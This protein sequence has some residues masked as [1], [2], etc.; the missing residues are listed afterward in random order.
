VKSLSTLR[1]NRGLSILEVLTAMFI[2]GMV[3]SIAY[4]MLF[5]ALSV[6]K[7]VLIEGEMRSRGEAVFSG[8][9][10]ELKDAVY[11]ENTV[12]GN[13][14]SILYIKRSE[15][16]ARYLEQY[17]MTVML[18]PPAGTGDIQVVHA[19]SGALVKSFDLGERFRIRE[20]RL[21]AEGDHNAVHLFLLYGHRNALQKEEQKEVKIDSRIPL[22]RVD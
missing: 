10:S 12:D 14:L 21:T 8:M 22:L 19:Q 7:S 6:Y 2:F 4:S 20:A 9:I 3:V 5:M 15:D 13:R 17:K 11:V 18:E 16:K 1:N